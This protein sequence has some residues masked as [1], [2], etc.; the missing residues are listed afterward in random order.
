MIMKDHIANTIIWT[1]YQTC[2]YFRYFLKLYGYLLMFT[3]YFKYLFFYYISIVYENVQ[4]TSVPS[5]DRPSSLS[6]RRQSPVPAWVPAEVSTTQ[7][8]PTTR[9]SGNSQGLRGS[10]GTLNLRGTEDSRFVYL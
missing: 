6:L 8:M 10:T 9:P 5:Y 7:T 1:S 2:I 3:D 4:I